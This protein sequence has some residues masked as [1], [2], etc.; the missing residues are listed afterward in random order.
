MSNEEKEKD[1]ND[2]IDSSSIDN[3]D[4]NPG[5]VDY[6]YPNY[7]TA[8]NRAMIKSCKSL[9]NKFN[10]SNNDIINILENHETRLQALTLFLKLIGILGIANL[11]ILILYIVINL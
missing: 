7:E 9:L 4:N 8:N 6:I 1:T 10:E 11:V 2:V 3:N 5:T